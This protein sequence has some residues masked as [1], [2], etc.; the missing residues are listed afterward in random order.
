M[1]PLSRYAQLPSFATQV[2]KLYNSELTQHRVDRASS[3][4]VLWR[5]LWLS[6]ERLEGRASSHLCR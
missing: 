3:R 1:L 2:Y 6:P 5:C 4:I